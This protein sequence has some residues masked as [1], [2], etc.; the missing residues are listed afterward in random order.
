M[1]TPVFSGSQRRLG[2]HFLRSPES[3]RNVD[4]FRTGALPKPGAKPSL[5]VLN[6]LF[7]SYDLVA[8]SRL[9]GR[10]GVQGV[11]LG[12]NAGLIALL[13]SFLAFPNLWIRIPPPAT[14]ESTAG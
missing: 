13:V 3:L 6:A 9:L 8:F 1:E 4:L 12:R 10:A 11:W 7:P 5:E 2:K 14:T